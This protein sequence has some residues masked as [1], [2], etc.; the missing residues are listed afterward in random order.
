MFQTL[1][2][3]G[4]IDFQMILENTKNIVSTV[5]MRNPIYAHAILIICT[6]VISPKIRYP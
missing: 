1:G 4:E 3:L 5:I 2:P 6:I